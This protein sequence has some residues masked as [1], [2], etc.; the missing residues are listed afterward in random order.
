[1][2]GKLT[3]KGLRVISRLLIQPRPQVI[4]G[5]E[6]LLLELPFLVEENVALDPVGI[7]FGHLARRSAAKQSSH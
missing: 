5:C 4:M 2:E 3:E 6:G 7:G 1:M